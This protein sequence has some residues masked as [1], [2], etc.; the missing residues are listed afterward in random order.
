M[1]FGYRILNEGKREQREIR[2]QIQILLLHM[3]KCKYQNGY[4]DKKSW[5]LSVRNAQSEILGEFDPSGRNYFRGSLYKSFYMQKLD[6]QERYEK[7]V[8]DAVDET[9]LTFQDFPSVCE[10]TKDQL[11]NEK[12]IRNFIEEWGQDNV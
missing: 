11:V 9:G 8:E 1:V 12:F 2:S 10:W 6:L 7:A 5:R 3:L 4:R